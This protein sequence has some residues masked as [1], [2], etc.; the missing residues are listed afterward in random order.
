MPGSIRTLAIVSTL[1]T[2][3]VY[4]FYRKTAVSPKEDTISPLRWFFRKTNRVGK[5]IGRQE[6]LV[7]ALNFGQIQADF[8]SSA[9]FIA[10]TLS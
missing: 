1:V 6:L 2:V 4:L 3:T 9:K 5:I 7:K 10:N 8:N